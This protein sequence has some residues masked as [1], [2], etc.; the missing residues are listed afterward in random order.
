MCGDTEVGKAAMA[1]AVPAKGNRTAAHADL[2]AL[3]A[4][5]EAECEWVGRDFAARARAA[6][7][8]GDAAKPVY[9]QATVREAAELLADG[10]PVAPLPFL[11][12]AAADA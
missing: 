2:A 1:P 8:T 10:V 9:G 7:A 3:R 6:H 11:P 12:T 4:R 5:V